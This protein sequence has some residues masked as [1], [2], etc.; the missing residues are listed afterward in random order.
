MQAFAWK[1]EGQDFREKIWKKGLKPAEP[2]PV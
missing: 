2:L 1:F